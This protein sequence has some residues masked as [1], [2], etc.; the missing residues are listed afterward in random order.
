MSDVEPVP[1][2][3]HCSGIGVLRANHHTYLGDV[4]YA[5]T[6]IEAPHGDLTIAGE[7]AFVTAPLD[8]SDDA[9]V[10]LALADGTRLAIILKHQDPLQNIYTFAG[11]GLYRERGA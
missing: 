2:V 1:D 10:S 3:E 11:I 7:F 6:V 8:L 4:A 9:Q 5:L